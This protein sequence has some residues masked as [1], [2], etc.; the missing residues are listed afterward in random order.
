MQTVFLLIA[1]G[2]LSVT[3]AAGQDLS[4]PAY[5][6]SFTVEAEREPCCTEG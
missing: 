5:D 1:A 6:I 3:G 4:V 2:A